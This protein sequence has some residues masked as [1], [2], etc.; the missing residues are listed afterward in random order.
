[1]IITKAKN[2]LVATLLM[3]ATAMTI[4]CGDDFKKT[5]KG[6]YYKF[7]KEN[8]DSLKVQPG[9]GLI[10]EI[11]IKFDTDT[12]ANNFGQPG[13]L[14]VVSTQMVDPVLYEGLLMLHKGDVATFAYDADSV[15]KSLPE[16]QT[17]HPKYKKGTGQQFTF[18]ISVQDI[19]PKAEVEK[20]QARYMEEVEKEMNKM[21]EEEPGKIEEYIKENKI[22]TKPTDDG[23][24]IIVQQK[25][26]GEKVTE[27]KEVT[28]H[29]TGC[30]LDGT[31]FDSSVE[32]NEPFTFQIGATPS[33]VIQGW[34]KALMGQTVGSKLQLIIPS[35]MA[36]GDGG[37]FF[38][39]YA[40]LVFD[41]EIIS[42]K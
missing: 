4:S 19:M 24:Y 8:T 5:E 18:K 9:D 17:L 2:I 38:Y 13:P 6:L 32:R 22:K 29:Y 16:G 41:V 40:T 31:K 10:G 20:E 39:P 42:V 33:Q 34:D 11:I 36:Y 7:E 23:I 14:F 37:G 1:M 27:G 12:I 15:A 35:S 30:L 25:G 28:V 21:K 3:T 26:K